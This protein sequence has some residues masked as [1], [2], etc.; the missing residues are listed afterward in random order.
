MVLVLWRMGV[1]T[2]SRRWSRK[3]LSLRSV[4]QGQCDASHSPRSS[5]TSKTAQKPKSSPTPRKSP[6]FS[7]IPSTKQSIKPGKKNSPRITRSWKKSANWPTPWWKPQ[8]AKFPSP[9]T[10][11]ATVVCAPIRSNSSNRPASRMLRL[12]WRIETKRLL[13]P[14]W[15]LWGE[16]W[17]TG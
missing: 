1:L 11:T 8:A 12:M 2:S 6:S 14:R 7:K 5:S 15:W 3:K 9:S 13:G 17:W 10:A 4:W 16:S